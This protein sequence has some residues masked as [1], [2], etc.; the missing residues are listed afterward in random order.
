MEKEKKKKKKMFQ[1]P[2]PRL[3]STFTNGRGERSTELQEGVCLLR[4]TPAGKA[5]FTG[6]QTLGPD[7]GRKWL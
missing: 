4:N 6:F 7:E 3:F 2:S 1:G 5:P